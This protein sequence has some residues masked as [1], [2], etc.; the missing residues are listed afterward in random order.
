[1]EDTTTEVPI[2]VLVRIAKVQKGSF[3]SLGSYAGDLP[4]ALRRQWGSRLI[5]DFQSGGAQEIPSDD[6]ENRSAIRAWNFIPSP[7]DLPVAV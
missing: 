1:M 6:S 3:I 5:Q 4:P 7:G 2:C